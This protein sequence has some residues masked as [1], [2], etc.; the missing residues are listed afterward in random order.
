MALFNLSSSRHREEQNSGRTCGSRSAKHS[1]PQSPVSEGYSEQRASAH[2]NDNPEREVI[3]LLR[4]DEKKS[5]CHMMTK[6]SCQTR[7]IIFC[8][9]EPA[10]AGVA[11]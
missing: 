10:L 4:D 1:F 8:H 7:S 3:S 11:I 2:V 9:C 5:E 6:W